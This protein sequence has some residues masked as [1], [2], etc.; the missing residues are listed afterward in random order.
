[1]YNVPGFSRLTK[2]QGEN[3]TR[4]NFKASYLYMAFE[5]D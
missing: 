1:M 3:K 4:K 2:K 5:F